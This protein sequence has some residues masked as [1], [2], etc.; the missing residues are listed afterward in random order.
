MEA[1]FEDARLLSLKME[2]TAR[3]KWCSFRFQKRAE[4][5]FLIGNT[6]ENMQPLSPHFRQWGHPELKRMI[7]GNLN[8]MVCCNPSTATESEISDS[9]NTHTY[10]HTC[11]YAHT[12]AHIHTWMCVHMCICMCLCLLMCVQ[13]CACLWVCICT[14]VYLCVWVCV[15][16]CVWSLCVSVKGGTQWHTLG[17]HAIIHMEIRSY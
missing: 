9:V 10:T 3:E 13:V 8:Y 1:E 5:T 17:I 14:C 12:H 4:N 11:T 6:K 2:E 7:Y 15:S 16:M